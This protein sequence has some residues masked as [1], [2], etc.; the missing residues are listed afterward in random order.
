MR[1]RP[2]VLFLAAAAAAFM[3]FLPSFFHGW[4]GL[5]DS[6]FLLDQTG[7]RGLGPSAWS[8]AFTSRIGSVYQPLAWLSY[9]VDYSLWGLDARGYH[10]Q[11]AVWHA[12]AAGF[13]ALAAKRLLAA[14]HDSL[15]AE[16]S[17]D[18]DA[19]AL[20]AALLF[21]LH[22]LR[23]E[24]VSWASERRDVVCCAFFAATLWSYLRA[25]QPGRPP[26]SL[27]P[28]VGL[29][30]CALL[31]KGMAVTLPLVLLVLDVYPLRRFGRPGERFFSILFEKTMFFCLS[32][33]A[34]VVGFAIQERM[35]WSWVQHD[36]TSRL[37]QSFYSLAFYV[38]KTLWPANLIPYYELRLPLNVWE[39]RFVFSVLAVL[40]VMGACWFWRRSRPWVAASAAIYAIL[41]FP[42]CG[43]FQFGPQLVA[44]RY[45]YLTCLP[46]AV[47]AAGVFRAWLCRRA[48]A[49]AAAA[50][51]L[52]VVL[53]AATL[54][55]Q[56]C[57]RG[58]EELWTRVLAVDPDCAMAH[59][60]LGTLQARRGRLEEAEAHFR[61]VFK[62]HPGCEADQDRLAVILRRGSPYSERERVL[63]V[64]VEENPACRKA[65]ANLGA[66][67]A[68]RGDFV[69]A[70]PILKTSVAVDPQSQTS[71]R[72]LLRVEAKLARRR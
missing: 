24:S 69:A 72:N 58:T 16:P 68:Q 42:V 49:S 14:A 28:A 27:W 34:V 15:D 70:E 31:A 71:R 2:A 56:R 67:L 55:Q 26:L 5:D 29:F 63:S 65:R 7:W 12:V 8:W 4:I 37:A 38:R 11:S 17:W 6:M 33:F 41:L 52:V 36:L 51:A 20:L 62:I 19:A 44:D 32:A 53:A 43:F 18:L 61:Q 35:R 48:R 59:V 60:G 13:F 10:V 50:A 3:V 47:L 22:P 46:W 9:G 57:W 66:L 30:A 1:V 54:R 25:R 39:P 40:A 45:S 64:T 23:V 21:A